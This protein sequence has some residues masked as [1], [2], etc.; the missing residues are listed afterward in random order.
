MRI[1]KY[2]L[3]ISENGKQ[4]IEIPEGPYTICDVHDNDGLPTLWVAVSSPN[5]KAIQRLSIW[6]V[7]TG[8]TTPRDMDNIWQY[9]GTAHCRLWCR[10]L[11]WHVFVKEGTGEKK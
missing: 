4:S 3:S 7:G 2:P 11:V 9:F 5:N 6:I 8:D 1:L 10:T